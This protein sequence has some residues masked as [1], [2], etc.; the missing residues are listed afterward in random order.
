MPQKKHRGRIFRGCILLSMLVMG[1]C[2]RT[3]PLISHAHL[4][5]AL[6]GWHDTP[7]QGG[8][9]VVAENEMANA[10]SEVALA[11]VASD[12]PALAK[13]HIKNVIHSLN[14][15]LQ[16]SGTGSGYG[17]VRAVQ[18]SI[19][20]VKFAA[21]SQDASQNLRQSAVD[22]EAH[23][24][25]M[26]DQLL[27]TVGAARLTLSADD[28]AFSSDLEALERALDH[29]ANGKDLDNDGVIGNQVGES[30]LR[31]LRVQL[32]TLLANEVAPAYHPVGRRYLFGLVK[33]PNGRWD[34]RFDRSGYGDEG[35]EGGG[36]G[37]SEGGGGGGGGGS[38]Y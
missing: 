5:H 34:Y 9:F 32:S 28:A 37:G 30:G 10:E 11:R 36:E 25:A 16:S 8:L 35:S 24:Q 7:Q 14:P 22:F 21:L 12:T 33:L 2:A 19:D 1:G 20:H 17:S 38:G 3:V 6:T 27:I 4:G 23:A 31:Q 26:L 15:D 29:T 18:G 13:I